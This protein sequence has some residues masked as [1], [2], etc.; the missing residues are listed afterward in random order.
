MGRYTLVYLPGL[1]SIS[2]FVGAGGSLSHVFSIIG[3]YLH[4]VVYSLQITSH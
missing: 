1:C 4:V 2:P 3:Q